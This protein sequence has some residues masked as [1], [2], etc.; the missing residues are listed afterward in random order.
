MLSKSAI[1]KLQTILLIDVII[2]AAAAGAYIFVASQPAPILDLAQIQLTALSVSQIEVVIG[3]SVTI[4]VNVTNIGTGTGS[5]VAS[6]LLDGVQ[7]QEKTIQLSAGETKTVEFVVSDAAEGTHS[8]KIGNL[9]GTFT[10]SNVFLLSDLAINRTEAKVG[11]PIGIQVKITNRAAESGNYSTQLM[12]NGT[13]FAT[14]TGGLDGGASAN[15]LFEVVEQAE[16]T[17]LFTI[18]SLNGSFKINPSA[19]PPR[20]AEFLLSNL[21]IDPTVTTPNS[22]ITISVNVTNVGETTGSYT[23][24]LK[25]NNTVAGTKDV[26]LAGGENTK[27][28]FN[29]TEANKGTYSVVV[30]NL[31]GEFSI[32][33]P[34][35]I[36]L[37]N[38]FVKPYEV[39]VGDNL[40]VNVKATNPDTS[41]SSKSVK[42][43]IDNVSVETKTVQLDGGASSTV[44]FTVTAQSEGPHKVAVN[45]LTGGG[46]MVVKTG[47]HTLSV[48]SSPVMGVD[49]TLDGVAHKTFYSELLPVGSYTVAVPPTD[50]TGRFTFQSWDTGSSSPTI[51]VNVNAQITVTASFTGGGSC[52]SLYIWNGTSDVYIAEISNHGWLGYIRYMNSDGSINFWRNN[53]WDYVKLNS[54]QLG[55]LNGTYFDLTLK[56][57]WNEIFY[58]D[59][60]HMMVVDHPA[61]TD[62]YSTMVEEYLD[63]N[64]MGQIYS[65]SK[66]PLVPVS[67]VNEKGENVLSQIAHEDGVS[68][69]GFNGLLSPA[70]NNI[71]WNRITLDLGNLSDAQQIKLVVKALVT[72]GPGENYATWLDKLYAAVA[73]GELPN[74]TMVTPPPIME[75]KDANGNW[76]PVPLSRQFPIPADGVART[77]VVD[78]TGLF[79]TSDHSLR[80]SNFWNTTFD[81][82]GID[83]TPQQN[84]TIQRID[85]TANLYH[86]FSTGTNATGNFTRFGDVTSLILTEDDKFVIG[87]QGDAVTLLFPV[88]GLAPLADSMQRDYFFFVDAWFKSSGDWGPM[89]PFAVDPLPFHN[90]TGYPYPLDSES[91]PYDADHIAYLNEWNNR[92]IIQPAEVQ[93]IVSSGN[94]FSALAFGLLAFAVAATTV[95]TSVTSIHYWQNAKKLKRL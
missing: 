35:R 4:S 26:Q 65:I 51:T 62:V 50:P 9:E 63:P 23:V 55:L 29:V 54:N 32:Q 11:E 60:A 59:S 93:N 83:T 6:L 81:Y 47:Y 41:P 44:L 52:P 21:L 49:F 90:M 28:V 82:I 79:P 39:W 43:L 48:S 1:T 88:A 3:Q 46:F 2:I 70:W 27:A 91:Y 61:G 19:P 56:Q 17:Y 36:T 66:N 69:T 64:Y 94:S 34:S 77:F 75:V 5:Y 14:K 22:P 10:V 86:S 45:E 67:A 13:S 87:M 16:G 89:F 33:E 68:T 72:W 58:L 84:M 78:L 30:G 76:V 80:I 85:P 40:T 12:I 95:T 71:Q 18:G 37:S 20:P 31:T 57:R 42:L 25:I 24:D 38:M 15:L 73:A 8:V 53:P 92:S 74:N 7:I